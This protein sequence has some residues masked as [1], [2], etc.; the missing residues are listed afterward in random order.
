MKLRIP[1]H[2]SDMFSWDGKHGCANASDFGGKPIADRVYD[3][4]CD[5]G[6]DVVSVNTNK[7]LLFTYLREERD[8]GNTLFDDFTSGDLT[9]TIYNN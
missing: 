1:L 6:F 7:V 5:V 8:K 2:S 3:D 4:A 9:I